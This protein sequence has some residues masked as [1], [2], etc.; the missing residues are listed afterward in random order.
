MIPQAT[1]LKIRLDAEIESV[2]EL[3]RST[4]HVTA[5]VNSEPRE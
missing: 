3:I 1:G 5:Q 4:S 2:I